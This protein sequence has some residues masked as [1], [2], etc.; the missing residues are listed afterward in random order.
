MSWRAFHGTLKTGP[1]S[2]QAPPPPK[3]IAFRNATKRSPAEGGARLPPTEL[4]AFQ[5]TPRQIFAPCEDFGEDS[6][7][8]SAKPSRWPRPW[9]ATLLQKSFVHIDLLPVKSRWPS[10]D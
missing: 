1:D 3:L 7:K 5:R 4:I 10:N 8:L 2:W 9:P 6:Q